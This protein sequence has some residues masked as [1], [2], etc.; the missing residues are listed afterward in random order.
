MGSAQQ[1]RDP[2]VCGQ[3]AGRQSQYS[4]ALEEAITDFGATTPFAKVA[5]KIKRHYGVDLGSSAAYIV[6]NSH[7]Q[8]MAEFGVLPQARTEAA[9]LIAEMDR[10]AW[11]LLCKWRSRKRWKPIYAKRAPYAGKS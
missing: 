3:R 1:A 8:A 7:A 9:V 10:A 11:P 5:K 6:T 2:S 4:L